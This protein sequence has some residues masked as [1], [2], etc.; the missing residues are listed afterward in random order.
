MSATILNLSAYRFVPL[1][2]LPALQARIREAAEAAGLRGTVLLAAEGINLFVAGPIAAAR[3]WL[4]ALREDPRLA[5]LQAKESLSETLPFRRLKVRIKREIIRMDMPVIQPAE[6]RAPAVAPQTLARWIEQGQDDAGRPL[7][8]LDTR[9]AFE[10]D[11]GAFADAIDWRLN[12]FS[13]FPAALA[14]HRDELQ[15]CTVVSYCTGGIRCEKAALVMQQL[16][17]DHSYQLEGG[18]LQYFQATGGR[19]P[20]WQGRCFVFDEREGLD[21]Q[22]RPVA[23]LPTP[24]PTAP[25]PA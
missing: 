22:L 4:E 3:A 24:D 25:R 13:E 14:A 21:P 6:G 11:A 9:N 7:R 16:G 17:L 19:A 1:D 18:I 12:R 2:G 5:G 20:G 10:V 8:L 15:G 23:G